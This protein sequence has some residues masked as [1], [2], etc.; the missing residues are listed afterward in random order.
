[1]LT[2]GGIVGLAT[3]LFQ[4]GNTTHLPTALGG[5]IFPLFTIIYTCFLFWGIMLCIAACFY[6]QRTRRWCKHCQ[7]AAG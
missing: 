3:V 6:A 2:I 7:M 1:M 5:L 4:I